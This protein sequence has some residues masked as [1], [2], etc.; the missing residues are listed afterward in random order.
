[1]SILHVA[2]SEKYTACGGVIGVN[3]VVVPTE[4]EATCVR[5]LRTCMRI[6]WSKAGIDTPE[7]ARVRAHYE[8]RIAQLSG[9]SIVVNET[10]PDA[11]PEDPPAP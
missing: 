5:C 1:M 9:E 4:E 3:N 2:L 6:K 8:P 7:G 11:P 10:Q